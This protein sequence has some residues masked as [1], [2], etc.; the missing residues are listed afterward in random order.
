MVNLSDASLNLQFTY[1]VLTAQRQKEE[2]EWKSYM[3]V[4]L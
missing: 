2:A 4:N 1:E 3:L